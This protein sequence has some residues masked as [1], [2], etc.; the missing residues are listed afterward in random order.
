VGSLHSYPVPQSPLQ[1]GLRK[2]S[3]QEGKEINNINGAP[4]RVRRYFFI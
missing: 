2:E 1:K 3:C 4:D